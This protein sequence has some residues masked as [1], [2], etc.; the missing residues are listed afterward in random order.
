MCWNSHLVAPQNLWNTLYSMCC[1]VFSFLFLSLFWL[2]FLYSFS[3]CFCFCKDFALQPNVY[4]T[5][6][7]N[8]LTSSCSLLRRH[9]MTQWQ[10]FFCALVCWQ[11]CTSH[12]LCH[13]RVGKFPTHQ[14]ETLYQLL[15]CDKHNIFV[16]SSFDD[17]C[18]VDISNPNVDYCRCT[19]RVYTLC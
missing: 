18:L 6:I 14:A 13:R 15:S 5:D 19:V 4:R 10:I 1:L 11:F 17:G 8:K 2:F 3:L 12:D 7:I 16:G 9:N